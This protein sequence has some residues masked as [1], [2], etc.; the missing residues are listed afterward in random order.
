MA[1]HHLMTVARAGE[2]QDHVGAASRYLRTATNG[3]PNWVLA[4]QTDDRA[5]ANLK[6][7]G[8]VG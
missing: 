7:M 8:L 3:K 1:A 5:G 2:E 6:G 4:S